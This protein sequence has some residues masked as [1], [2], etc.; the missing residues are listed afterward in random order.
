MLPRAFLLRFLLLRLTAATWLVAGLGL[1]PFDQINAKNIQMELLDSPM[2]ATTATPTSNS[3][4][5]S[6]SLISNLFT[7]IRIPPQSEFSKWLKVSEANMAAFTSVTSG[8]WGNP[9]TWGGA[10]VPGPDD[11]VTISTNTSVTLDSTTWARNLTINYAGQLDLNGND[12]NLQRNGAVFTNNG[13]LTNSSAT[14]S[15]FYFLGDGPQNVIT[16]FFGGT[17]GGCSFATICNLRVRLTNSVVVS[18]LSGASVFNLNFTVDPSTVLSLDNDLAFIGSFTQAITITNNGSIKNGHLIT[19]RLVTLTG[20][21]LLDTDLSTG[22]G[23]LQAQ[24]DLK[25]SVSVGDQGTFRMS[26]D[27]NVFGGITIDS[28][29]TLNLNGHSLHFFG[30]NS[31]FLNAGGTVA[32][33]GPA[34]TF[35]FA[36]NDTP[37]AVTQHLVTFGPFANTITARCSNNVKV[38]MDQYALLPSVFIDS[39]STLDLGGN[40]L[41]LTG[42]GQA[43]TVQGTILTAGSTMEMNGTAAQSVQANLNGAAYNN[44][45]INNAAGVNIPNPGAN[46]MTVPGT[47]Y[48]EAGLFTPN[49]NLT[50]GDG[51]TIERSDGTIAA[52]PII[53]STINI[54]YSEFSSRSITSGPEIPAA[55]VINNFHDSNGFTV[56][57]NSDI[58]VNGSFLVDGGNLSGTA[59]RS[60]VL[61][62][63][64]VSNGGTVFYPNITFDSSGVQTL[65][66][67]GSW[68]GAVV[69]MLG[70]GGVS[71]TSHVNFHNVSFTN[72]STINTGT[73]FLNFYGSTFTNSG[74]INGN[75]QTQASNAAVDAGNTGFN[76]AFTVYSGMAT[77]KGKVN[78]NLTIQSSAAALQVS[79]GETLTVSGN[80]SINGPLSGGGTFRANGSLVGNSALVSVANFQLGGITQIFNGTGSISGA[81]T[82]F[83]GS[84]TTLGND[85]QLNSLSISAGGSFNLSNRTLLL[86]GS[87]TPFTNAGVFTSSTGTVEY[88]GTSAQTPSSTVPSYFNLSLNNTAGTSAFAG[89][90]VNGLL[91]IKA[92]VFTGNAGTIKNVQIDNGSIYAGTNGTLINV[93]GNWTNNGTFTP[94]L[95]T[96]NFS[97]SATQLISGTNATTFDNLTTSGG[98]IVNLGQNISV[99]GVLT[100]GSDL[101]TGANTLTMPAT[102]TSAGSADVIGNIKRTGFAEGGPALGFGNPFNSVAFAP[103]GT[104]PSNVTFNLA[105][106]LSPGFPNGVSRSYII[107]STGGSGFSATLRLHYLDSEL[108]GNIEADLQLYRYNG[109]WVLQ[110][111]NGRDLADNWVELFNVTQFSTWTLSAN[112]AG[113]PSPTNTATLTP[114]TTP[115]RTA[116]NTPTVTPSNT[117][118]PVQTPVNGPSFAIS[119]IYDRRSNSYFKYNYIELKNVTQ[120]PQSLVLLKLYYGSST[121]NFAST[122][123][124]AFNL[125]NVTLAPGQHYLVQVGPPNGGGIAFNVPPDVT[126]PN[127]NM[128]GGGSGKV[129]LVTGLLPINTCGSAATPC[130]TTQLSY[131]VDWVAWGAAGNGTAGNGEGGTSVNNGVSIPTI[132]GSVRMDAGCQDTNNNNADFD[133]TFAPEPRNSSATVLCAPPTATATASPSP[134]NTATA[135]STATLTPTPTAS[136][137]PTNTSTPTPTASPCGSPSSWVLKAPYPQLVQQ[138][139]V[140]TDGNSIYV[141]GGYDNNISSAYNSVNRYNPGSDSWTPLAPMPTGGDYGVAAEYGENGKIYVMGGGRSPTLNRI[142]DIASGTWTSGAAL[143]AV[144]RSAAHAY[145]GGKVY[146]IGGSPSSDVATNSVYAY[147]IATN[148]WQTLAPLPEARYGSDAVAMNGKLYVAGGAGTLQTVSGSLFI[149]DIAQDTWVLGTNEPYGTFSAAASVVGG[150]FWLMGGVDLLGLGVPTQIY[151]P[152]NDTWSLGPFLNQRK[153]YVGASTLRTASTESAFIVGGFD[154]GPITALNSVETSTV[155][156]CPPTAT[157]TASPSPTNTS[158]ATNTPTPP[159]SIGGT[160]TYGN[161]IGAPTPRFVS[162]VTVTGTGPSTIFSTTIFPNGNYSLTGFQPGAYTVT[163]TKTGGINGSISS[164]DAAKIA[165][166]VAGIN[167]LT[168]N[169]L[170]VADVSSNGTISSFDA[171]QIARYVAAVSGFGSTGNWRFNPVNRMYASVTTNITGEDYSALLMGEVSGNWMNTGARPSGG[172]AAMPVYLRR[173]SASPVSSDQASVAMP[174][175]AEPQ[176]PERRAPE[177]P[178]FS[179]NRAAEPL[180]SVGPEQAVSVEL[181]NL[182][183]AVDKEV[184]IPI[185]AQGAADKEIISYE[186]NLRYDPSVIQPQSDPVDVAGTASRG[187]SYVTNTEEPGL[188][189]VVMYGAMPIDG[190]GVLLNLRFTAVGKAGSVSPLMWERIMFNEG[191]PRV[192]TSDGQVEL[193]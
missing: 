125:P 142:Y 83:N 55:N 18:T 52:T 58:I 37:G 114:T 27:T 9:V 44:L 150:N 69:A 92:G 95:N 148:T 48:L 85:K 72:N 49:G 40:S 33:S 156:L 112:P 180:F 129:A 56:T 81:V 155:I 169:Q 15:T 79:A 189:R 12:F 45:T 60:L 134:T 61:K 14:F 191:D 77:A 65:D 170:V 57:L 41:M 94:N 107:T 96:V 117:A 130:S 19:S 102:G 145:Y 153:R 160:I 4:F 143:Q 158:T 99:N 152:V 161:A 39:G 108:N 105:K 106:T 140:T 122:A 91:R 185:S 31:T 103:G 53:A 87:G 147:Q 59:N 47:L 82:I 162:N 13:S 178:S 63:S 136:P 51:S 181:P 118:T 50:M 66:N 127:L 131:I 157:A 75:F 84:T 10:G 166:H 76:A 190:D 16:Q 159:V 179:A 73:Y 123:S 193:F 38:I 175:S 120:T 28:G 3:N 35:Y 46:P 121:G 101:S 11:S 187:L 26:G 132:S 111:A 141:F 43:L 116:T 93:T 110:G 151:D 167:V 21:G 119:Q 144:R 146:V 182:S 109:A 184:V 34:S 137:S 177:K 29:G 186:F 23:T 62:G 80:C 126:T 20:S 6:S 165:Q 5:A 64:P 104:L 42:P 36:G 133:V 176:D 67:Y 100:L 98:S 113:T 163:P 154:G 22:D 183:A 135:T 70:T 139:G 71:L 89:L 8:S 32:N 68:T 171:G 86:S 192:T 174:P 24:G 1:M 138:A 128:S 90:T 17:S 164:F 25:R 97:A 7:W 188:V 30:D 78:S 168:G 124:D 88:N 172:G 173:N 74:V 2:G 149:Y 115:T 54:L